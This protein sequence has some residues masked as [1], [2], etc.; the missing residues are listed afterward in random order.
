MK[1]E[2]C[3]SPALVTYRRR[4]VRRRQ[5]DRRA[6]NAAV[7][8]TAFAGA[9]RRRRLDRTRRRRGPPGKVRYDHLRVFFEVLLETVAALGAGRARN[10]AA[11]ARAPTIVTRDVD[12]RRSVTPARHKAACVGV[13]AAMLPFERY[14]VVCRQKSCSPNVFRKEW[15][16]SIIK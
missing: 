16:C 2:L 1:I 13:V 5:S 12:S 9:K 6:L 8:V 4:S 11:C 3:E 15:Y 7:E 14:K 10:V